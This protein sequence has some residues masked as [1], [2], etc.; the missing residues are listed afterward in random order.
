M[1]S[2]LD[3]ARDGR[4]LLGGARLGRAGGAHRPPQT[5]LSSSTVAGSVPSTTWQARRDLEL[6]PTSASSFSFSS[7]WILDR[8]LRPSWMNTWQAPHLACPSHLLAITSPTASRACSRVLPA[9][10]S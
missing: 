6:T 5:K 1:G 8:P 9:V 10:A 7:F 2:L 3:Q 4:S